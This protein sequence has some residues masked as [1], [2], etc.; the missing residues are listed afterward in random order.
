M[1]RPVSSIY[2]FK[3]T[4]TTDPEQL[5]KYEALLHIVM[6]MAENHPSDWRMKMQLNWATMVSI[7]SK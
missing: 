7:N 5:S 1:L 6:R 2:L 4:A 3:K